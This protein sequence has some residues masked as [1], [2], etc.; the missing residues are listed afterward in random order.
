[1]TKDENY[2]WYNGLINPLYE[3][4]HKLQDAGLEDEAK[5]LFTTAEMLEENRDEVYDCW[6]A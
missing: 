1:M 4:A 5:N 6:E 2:E 3:M